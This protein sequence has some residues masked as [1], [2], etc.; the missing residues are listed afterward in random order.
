MNLAMRTRIY[1]GTLVMGLLLTVGL[2]Q[3]EHSRRHRRLPAPSTDSNYY[4]NGNPSPA[5]VKLGRLLFFDKILGGNENVSCATCHHPLADTG[6]GLSLP[7]GEGGRGLGMIR[8]TGTGPDAVHERVPRNAPPVFNLGAFEFIF[9]FDDG[10]VALDPSHP[11]GFATP[12]GDDLPTGLQTPLAAQAM[13]P[14][15]SFT[16]MAGQPG[17]NSIA[18]ASNAGN[19]AGPGGVWEQLADRLRAIPEYVQLFKDAFPG[20]VSDAADMTIVQAAN[21]IG[22]FEARAWR[23]DNSPFDRFLRG[24]PRAMSPAAIRGMQIFYGSG[25]CSGCHSGSYQ[26]DNQFHSIAMPQIGP[27]KG[28]GPDGHDDYGRERVTH[29]SADRYKFR[30]PTLRNVELTGP[31]GHD[32]AYNTLEGVV[33]HHLHPI[34]SLNH[35][36]TSQVA[37]PS[38]PDLDALDFIVQNDPIRRSAIGDAN[39]LEP[40]HLR[41]R[42]VADLI[43]FLRAL[44]DPAS[45]DLRHDVPKRV[46]SGLPLAE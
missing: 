11:S 15:T 29:D 16:E 19:L 31:W 22:A 8:D 20:E 28:D 1:T 34:F 9:M 14:I 24:N 18:D 42:D 46:P 4:Y 27:G 6:D 13:F 5:M 44:T 36:D 17:E 30:T 10:R 35:Y 7:I 43:E 2:A 39:E 32:G 41:D 38:R 21:A 40:V 25:G 37:L 45:I 23:S 26:T 12:A 3:P 33:R